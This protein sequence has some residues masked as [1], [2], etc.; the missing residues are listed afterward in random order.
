MIPHPQIGPIFRRQDSGRAV[1][2]L[3]GFTATPDV[4]RPLAN[5]LFT[6]GYTVLAPL[7]SGHGG[8]AE[9]L[10][11]S[12][13]TDWYADAHKSFEELKKDHDHVFVAGL[14]MGGLLTLKLA[15]DFS[16]QIKA[17]SLLLS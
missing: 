4:M 16:T 7:L 8:T 12:R 2:L 17:I 1:L 9:R 13:W 3:H 11:E 6:A 10:E 15:E 5:A 14:S